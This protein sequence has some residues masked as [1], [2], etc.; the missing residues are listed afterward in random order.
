MGNQLR[1]I[2]KEDIGFEALP[3]RVQLLLSSGA[4][5]TPE[6]EPNK[7]LVI[8]TKVELEDSKWTVTQECEGINITD[9]ALPTTY[10]ADKCPWLALRLISVDN[11]DYG[12]SYVEE[13]LGDLISLEGLTKAIVEGSIAAA[14]TLFFVSPN[15][16]T[17]KKTIG[18]QPYIQL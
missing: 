7:D 16:S 10:P 1:L 12:H 14:K 11:E 17:R 4:E 18:A 5:G 3:E 2:V 6:K 15:G 13:Y 8:Y 9:P